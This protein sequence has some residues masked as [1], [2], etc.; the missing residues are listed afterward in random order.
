MRFETVFDVAEAGYQSWLFPVIGIF[1]VI[2][3]AAMVIF[4][5]EVGLLLHGQPK[6]RL[7]AWGLLASATVGTTWT[8]AATYS[9]YLLARNALLS[10]DYAIVEGPVTDFIPMRLDG[11]GAE[12]FTVDGHQFSYSNF[13]IAAGFN[14]TR[15]N[16]EPLRNGTYVRV[17]YD[18]RDSILRLEIGRQ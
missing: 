14:S 2:V 13:P 6:S 7:Y 5:K 12:K 11:K 16:G 9:D 10:R 15:S 4:P 17:T 8:L 18:R 1:F 3:S